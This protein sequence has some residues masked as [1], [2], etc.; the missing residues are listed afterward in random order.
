MS[1]DND[2]TFAKARNYNRGD[3]ESITSDSKEEAFVYKS[4]IAMCITQTV[5]LAIFLRLNYIVSDYIKVNE[6]FC[7]SNAQLA[8]TNGT[9]QQHSLHLQGIAHSQK[10]SLQHLQNQVNNYQQATMERKP[11]KKLRPSRG[12]FSTFL[13]S[14]LE[15]DG[16]MV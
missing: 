11:K 15:S 8:A 16:T 2:P 9:L 5:L 3:F 12:N 13:L 4:R 10:Q 7:H 6:E 14:E 1:I